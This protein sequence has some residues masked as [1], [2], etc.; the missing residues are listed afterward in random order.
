MRAEPHV[1]Q[2]ASGERVREATVPTMPS[3][4]SVP[5]TVV[6]VIYCWVIWSRVRVRLARHARMCGWSRQVLPAL[7]VSGKQLAGMGAEGTAA[8]IDR[9]TSTPQDRRS[10]VGV[11]RPRGLLVT[12]SPGAVE[13]SRVSSSDPNGAVRAAAVL[14]W[15]WAAIGRTVE[16]QAPLLAYPTSDGGCLRP[17]SRSVSSDHLS[18]NGPSHEDPL[19]RIIG[20]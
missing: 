1:R 7:T 13:L 5:E 8:R 2:D 3:A 10:E 14:R 19:H 15:R 4:R 11:N 20:W 18:R 12:E 9:H 16:L 17:T 6:E